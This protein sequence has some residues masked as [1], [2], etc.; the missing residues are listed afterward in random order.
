VDKR[1][2]ELEGE[3]QAKEEGKHDRCLHPESCAM[4]LSHEHETVVGHTLNE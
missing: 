2:Q 3:R 1:K 4:Q